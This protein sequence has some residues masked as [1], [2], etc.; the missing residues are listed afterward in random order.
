M[1]SQELRAPILTSPQSFEQ[2]S[3]WL[4]T[5]S[6]D[7]QTRRRVGR[8][9]RFRDLKNSIGEEQIGDKQM[10]SA[11]R[12]NETVGISKPVLRLV[13]RAI[14]DF[15]LIE[16]GDR[17]AVGMS[18][19]KDSLLLAVVLDELSRR[20]EL[21]FEVQPIHLD[22][23]QPGFDRAT[24]EQALSELGL[25]C[26][27]IERDTHS[28]VQSQLKPGQIPCALCSRMRRGIL[29][30]FCAERGFNKLALGHHLDD[31]IE[32]FFLNLFFG[33]RL[34]PMKPSTPTEDGQVTT[35]RP[36]I[37]VEERKVASWIEE[38]AIPTVACPVCDSFPASKRRDL[39]HLLD[40]FAAL[41]PDMHASV[42]RALYEEA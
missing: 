17:V 14:L 8:M 27:A 29:N 10:S 25:R 26:E 11:A 24:F 20:S 40:D 15:G 28:V 16:P 7:I 22:Q 39:K 34:D 30:D 41:Q 42:R 21:D 2:M 9:R 32:T 1:K 19:G 12:K 23:R 38:Y 18:G 3:H 31:A 33:R 35:I 37:L 4:R 36:L 13:R 6:R 5:A